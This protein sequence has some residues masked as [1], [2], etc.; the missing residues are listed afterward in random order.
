M[1]SGQAS[2]AAN[3]ALFATIAAL[4]SGQATGSANLALFAFIVAIG[5]GQAS[6][7][8]NL[9]GGIPVATGPPI[10]SLGLLHVGR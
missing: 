2:G 10:G 4:G 3:L 5:S 7:I 6:G 9:T 1:R 8:A